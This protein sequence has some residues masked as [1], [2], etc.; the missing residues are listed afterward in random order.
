MLKANLPLQTLP[1]VRDKSPRY[2]SITAIQG[3]PT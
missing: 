1:R 3:I 2:R